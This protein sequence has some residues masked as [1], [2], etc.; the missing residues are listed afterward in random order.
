MLVYGGQTHLLAFRGKDLQTNLCGAVQLC[1]AVHFKRIC[2]NGLSRA[3]AKRPGPLTP[4]GE[5]DY[6]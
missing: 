3:A 2:C 5:R 4:F 1:N 6:V